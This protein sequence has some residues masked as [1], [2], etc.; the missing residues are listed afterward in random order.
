MQSVEKNTQLK[1]SKHFEKT[2]LNQAD[3]ILEN[4][5]RNQ[6]Q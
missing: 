6:F 2:R 3:K 4:L 1:I 5:A